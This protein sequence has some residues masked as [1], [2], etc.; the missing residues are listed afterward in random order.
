MVILRAHQTDGQSS[1]SSEKA[2]AVAFYIP[3]SVIYLSIM[4]FLSS[5][6][7][8]KIGMSSAAASKIA[9][10][11]PHDSHPSHSLGYTVSNWQ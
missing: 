7:D 3:S 5:I 11:E 4:K 6:V 10:R 9:A 1:K 8:G 2:V